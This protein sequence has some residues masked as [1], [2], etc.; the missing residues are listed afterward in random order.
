MIIQPYEQSLALLTDLY[1]LTMCYGYWRSG[2]IDTHAV[3]H[4]EFRKHPFQGGFT[5]ACGLESAISWINN[6]AFSDS[7]LQYLAS[8]TGNDDQPLFHNDFLEY[9]RQLRFTCD[10]D[11]VPEG[12]AVFPHEPLV[13]VKGPLIQCQ[14]LE[15]PLLNLI[16]FPTLVAT[17]AARMCLAT[18]G[19]PILEFGLRRAQG[20][21]GGLTASRA[22]YVGGCAAT[23]NVLAGKIYGIPVKGTH[24]H[25]WVMAFD[26]ELE[27]FQ[28][29]A[30]AM[31]NNC[32]F[33]VDTYDTLQGVRHA[34]EVGRWLRKQGRDL[35]GIRLDSGDLAY[36]SIEARKLLDAAG[37]TQTA[38]LASND[39]DES[40]IDSLKS[41]GA[42][43]SVWGVGTRLATAYDQPALG[44]VY[45]LSAC[46]RHGEDWQ[47]RLKLSEQTA[48]ISTPG[49]LQIRRYTK[50]GEFQGDMIYHERFGVGD[51]TMLDPLDHTKQKKMTPAMEHEDLLTPI[52]R[53][54]KQVYQ[55]P[56]LDQVRSRVA[57][58]LDGLHFGIKRFINPH[59]YPVG[60]ERRLH[61]L[62]TQ[63]V[64]KARRKEI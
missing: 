32:V 55:V 61:D 34:I 45:K 3:F 60:L 15:T 19:E 44:G 18:K 6:F 13:R 27:A 37:F 62:R 21:D 28:A 52:Y 56:P 7:D 58:Q 24:A 10:I 9:L 57:R 26:T 20:M 31:P 38:I 63:L 17:K 2:H 35:L 46:R 40:V 39:L 14:L 49:I 36:L 41:Q 50:D 51:G 42:T 59:I 22:A 4:L 54:G 16:N 53:E 5:I 23:S 25:S 33:L 8:L 48:K 12:T 47:F 29:Y 43:I 1:Q 11:A 30:E 64:L